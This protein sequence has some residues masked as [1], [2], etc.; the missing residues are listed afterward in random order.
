MQTTSNWQTAQTNVFSPLTCRMG[1]RLWCHDE[2][3]LLHH[4]VMLHNTSRYPKMFRFPLISHIWHILLKH[5]PIFGL[6]SQSS[7]Y[8]KLFQVGL[9]WLLRQAAML[10]PSLSGSRVW[11][12]Q[13]GFNSSICICLDC[14]ENSTN[15]GSMTRSLIWL[16]DVL[17]H[18]STY[19][20]CSECKESWRVC[21]FVHV[22]W[23]HCSCLSF[24]CWTLAHSRAKT[25][26]TTCIRHLSS[27]KTMHCQISEK[28][29]RQTC[30]LELPTFA[31]FPHS[32][33]LP[34]R[35]RQP[36]WNENC[37][38]LHCIHYVSPWCIAWCKLI[39]LTKF[40]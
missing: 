15:K 26:L 19:R 12:G 18:G 30:N 9:P 1:F 24:L 35:W 20:V 32:W 27:P 2:S 13:S 36:N 3:Q 16:R 40:G 14:L 11:R 4:E 10:C 39:L 5:Y 21:P 23:Q 25:K 37:I 7:S 8:S 33:A 34:F 17:L 38:E 6:D 29:W 31:T 22:A 28:I